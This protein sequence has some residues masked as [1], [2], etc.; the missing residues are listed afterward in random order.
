[1]RNITKLAQIVDELSATGCRGYFL[2]R[3]VQCS[4]IAS[5][6]PGRDIALHCTVQHCFALSRHRP[7]PP[8]GMSLSH[9]FCRATEGW[10]LPDWVGCLLTCLSSSSTSWSVY[11]RICDSNLQCSAASVTGW[12]AH[13]QSNG[14]SYSPGPGPGFPVKSVRWPRIFPQWTP[15]YFFVVS[16]STY[17]DTVTASHA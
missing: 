14:G 8:P 1:M 7:C 16:V 4:H 3:H 15:L 12:P 10:P 17:T 13:L 2:V 9:R 5:Q 11:L 6:Q